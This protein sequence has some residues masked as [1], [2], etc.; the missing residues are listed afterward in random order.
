MKKEKMSTDYT[1][2]A[3]S[4]HTIFLRQSAILV[5]LIYLDAW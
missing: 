4:V 2:I 1:S 5:F 3:Y